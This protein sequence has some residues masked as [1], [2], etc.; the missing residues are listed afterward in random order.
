MRRKIIK[1]GHNTLTITLPSEWARK[2]NLEAGKEI[3]I[4]EK[5]NGLFLTTEKNGKHKRAEFDISD[6]AIPVIWKYFMAVYREGY[7]EVMVKFTPGTMLE[8]PYKFFNTHKL[9][10]KYKKEIQKRPVM[11]T[12]Q[13]FIN[14][15]IGFEIVEHGKDYILIKEM[16]ELTNREFDNSLR[17]I[18]LL[19]QQ[20]FDETVEV[21]ETGDVQLLEHMHDVD[22]NIDKFQD[23]CIRILNRVGNKEQ[24]KASILFATLYFLELIGD[25]FKNITHHLLYDYP[26]LKL[27]VI[28]DVTASIRDEFNLFYE[29]YYKFDKEKIAKMSQLD[30]ERYFSVN[31]LYKKVKD[32]EIKEIFH[33]IR[34]IAR[35]MNSLV[36]LRVELEF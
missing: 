9:D 22:I 10:L 17:R 34:I 4:E 8:N 31:S 27:K 24:R 33:H 21:V 30:Q 25:E 7:D 6:M 11:E 35:Y 32:E 5:D 16:G 12:L 23:Y 14:R 29:L 2:F 26:P 20:M 18:F 28:K 19:L 3:D 13:G 15:F 1:Q 36:E